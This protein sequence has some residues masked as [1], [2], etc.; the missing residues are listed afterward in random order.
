MDTEDTIRGYYDALRNGEVLHRYFA[1]DDSLVKFGISECLT[2]YEEVSQGLDEQ[3]RRTEDWKVSSKDLRVTERGNH[4]WFSDTVRM[5]WKDTEKENEYDFDSR[6]SG[7][8][9]KRE[10]EWLFVGMHVSIRP[11]SF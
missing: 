1:K 2:G 7:T 8:L 9:E 10:R 5:A 11:D 4:A 6:W 3:T